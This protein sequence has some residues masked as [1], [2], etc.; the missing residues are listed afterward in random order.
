MLYKVK[1]NII[2]LNSF[3]SIANKLTVFHAYEAHV[4][5]LLFSPDV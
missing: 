2:E 5:V 3:L 1:N 4:C